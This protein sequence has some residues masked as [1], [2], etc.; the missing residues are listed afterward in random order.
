MAKKPNLAKGVKIISDLM[1][2]LEIEE[3][4]STKDTP[5]RV[6]KMYLEVFKG[7]YIQHP[8]VITFEANDNYVCVTDIFFSSFCFPRRT[9]IRTNKG[10]V[11]SE[12]VKKG[13]ILLTFDKNKKIVS[14][15]VNSVKVRKVKSLVKLKFSNG[16]VL[17]PTLEHPFFSV[18]RNTFIKADDIKIGEKVLSLKKGYYS[19]NKKN[20]NFKKN[21]SLGYV[22]GAI[23]SDGSIARNAIS[24]EVSSKD[25]ANKFSKSLLDCFGRQPN[26]EHIMKFSGFLNKKIQQYRVRLVSGKAVNIIDELFGKRKKTFTFDVPNVV[27]EDEEIFHGYVDGYVDGD[28]FRFIN[29]NKVES[30]LQINSKNTIVLNTLSKIF[31]VKIN[32]HKWGYYY[33]RKS[34][35]TYMKA[36]KNYISNLKVKKY[37]YNDYDEIA[38]IDKKLLNYLNGVNVYSYECDKKNPTFL[39]GDIFVHNCSHHLLPFIGK[40]GVVYHASNGKVIGISKIPRIVEFWASRPQLQENLTNQIAHDLMNNKILSPKGVYVVMSAEHSCSVIRGVKA[41]GSK[42]NT[43]VILGDIDKKEANNL[44]SINKFFE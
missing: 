44:L 3:C 41:V 16:K 17:K 6:A 39:A 15:K 24:L 2:W 38:L 28:G 32:Y 23:S 9:G 19:K 21:Y 42:T 43:A 14:T 26:V 31:D 35:N 25:F 13:D 37:K 1:Q 11:F 27:F 22:L 12:N 34:I 10:V 29:K 33:V 36:Y 4:D 7:L 18:D 5:K 30:Y 20:I 40:C 8:K